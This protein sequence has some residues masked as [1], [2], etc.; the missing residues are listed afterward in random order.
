MVE[1]ALIPAGSPELEAERA[2]LTEARAVLARM[3]QDVVGREVQVVGG[4]D[5]NERFT[6]E[7]NLRAKQLRT[8]TL[9]DLPDVPLFFG[10]LDYEAGTIDEIDRIY[11]GRRH[12]HDGNGAP[13]V[14]DWRAPLSESTIASAGPAASSAS[15][16]ALIASPSGSAASPVK[17]PP[18]PSFGVS[19]AVARV[20]PC[21]AK[22]IGKNARTAC[23][24]TTGSDTFIMVAFR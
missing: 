15:N 21:C 8:Q 19:P 14:I 18:S 23:P 9:L 24:N 16:D 13:L 6:N 12:V 17:I 10:R 1:S 20:S 2:F 4:E 3:H 7:S 5:N 22:V 11:I